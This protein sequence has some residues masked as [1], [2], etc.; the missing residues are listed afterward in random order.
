MD[1][2]LGIEIGIGRLIWITENFYE[3]GGKR[4]HE[5]GFYYTMTSGSDSAI[6]QKKKALIGYE[7]DQRLIFRWYPLD[8]L[9]EVNIYPQFL[10]KGLR[11]IP[12]GIEHIIIR[13]V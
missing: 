12:Q 7:G 1:E 6:Y 9:K 2:E 5:I 11:N 13:G 3:S 8:E 4:V 10:Q